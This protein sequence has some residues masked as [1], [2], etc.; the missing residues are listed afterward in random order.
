M[1]ISIITP[2]YN[3][4]KTISD[5]LDSV[6]SQEYKNVEH[7]IIDGLSSDNTLN[8]I[9]EYQEESEIRL[10]SEKDSGIYDAM[11]KGVSLSSGDIVG[12]LN[13]DDIYYS[14]DV[15]NK[16][17]NIF[18]SDNSID[19][20]Y[21]DLIYVDRNNIDKIVRT[22]KS[23][24]YSESKLNWGW[25]IPHPSLF[26]QKRVYDKLNCIFNTKLSLAADYELILRLLK[27]ER[28]KVEYINE[29][30]VRMRE[31]GSSASSLFSRIKGWKE[32]RLSW[33]IN[34]LRIPFLFIIRR[35][36]IKIK[37]FI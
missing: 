32:L 17:V 23:G 22:W 5:T 19:A 24:E 34:K 18:K 25:T 4:E 27:L 10:I 3:S 33:K 37:Q 20:V 2:T 15:L 12:I 30:L 6:L 11:N 21:G 31:G 26:V 16:V 36:L 28:I 29:V 9:R 35:L 8:I 13:S 14:K 1:K 7:I